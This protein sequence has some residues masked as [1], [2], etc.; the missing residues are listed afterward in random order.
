MRWAVDGRTG[1]DTDILRNMI[2]FAAERLMEVEVGAK[3]GVGFGSR[4]PDR[5][6]QRNGYRD[7]GWE[8]RAGTVE[9]HIPKLRK[10]SGTAADGGESPHHGDPGGLHGQGVSTRTR[11]TVALAIQVARRPRILQRNKLKRFLFMSNLRGA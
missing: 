4:S 2:T 7:Q 6:V 1:P 5:Q 8:R 11:Q 9:L 10:L 3:T